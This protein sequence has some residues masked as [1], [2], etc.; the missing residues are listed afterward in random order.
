M[1]EGG[2]GRWPKRRG[3]RLLRRPPE[4]DEADCGD[5]MHDLLSLSPLLA[6]TSVP[7][8]HDAQLDRRPCCRHKTKK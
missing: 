5:L 3:K 7:R 8:S 4:Q 1:G 6:N 2:R